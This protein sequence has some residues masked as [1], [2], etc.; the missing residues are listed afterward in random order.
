MAEKP[1]ADAREMC[2]VERTPAENK[3]MLVRV[4]ATRLACPAL[5]HMVHMRGNIDRR[6]GVAHNTHSRLSCIVW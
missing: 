4:L 5:V 3:Y 2:G 6:H 1:L